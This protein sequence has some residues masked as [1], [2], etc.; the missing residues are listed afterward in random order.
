MP[1]LQAKFIDNLAQMQLAEET[2]D[3]ENGAGRPW[4]YPLGPSKRV[5]VSAAPALNAIGECL[6]TRSRR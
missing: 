5:L 6:V 3:D 2:S 4:R 1:L